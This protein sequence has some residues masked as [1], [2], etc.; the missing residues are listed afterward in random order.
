M[1]PDVYYASNSSD[2]FTN[3]IEEAIED[4]LYYMDVTIILNM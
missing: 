3:H 1:N 4:E 2:T